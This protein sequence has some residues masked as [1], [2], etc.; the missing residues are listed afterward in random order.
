MRLLK[1][2]VAVAVVAFA[3]G[4]ITGAVRG[5]AF[6]TLVIGVATAVLAVFVYARVVRWSERRAPVEVAR[7]GAVP[8]LGRGMLIGAGMF[9]AVIVNIAFSG[10]YRVDGLGSV[11][12][13]VGL[14]GFMAAAAVTEELLFR[15]VLFRIVEEWTGTWIAL[16]LTGLLFGLMHLTN[17]HA[18]LW[19]AIAIAIE[20]G[21][22]LAAAYAA[23]RTL[24][25]P[26]GLHF[27]WNFA[28]AGVF[29]TE[30]SGNGVQE[31][32]L[33]G[34]TSGPALLTGGDFGPEAS[35]YAV[36]FGALL[37]I[38]FLWLAHRRGTLV[39]R[40]RRARTGAAATLS[41]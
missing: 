2:L 21:G 27:G 11:T 39:P 19:G 9:A 26:I 33:N 5:N 28:A 35:P 37:T 6:L 25:L 41:Q 3:G 1:Q 34:V 4:A 16:T 12:G 24:W 17:Q 29:G 10:G 30:V 14:L 15:G 38:V 22:M 18:N 32:L 31:G 36:L 23:T 13:A 20:A 8:A 40:R 7:K